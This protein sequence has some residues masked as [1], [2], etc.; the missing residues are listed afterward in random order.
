MAAPREK[1]MTTDKYQNAAQQRVLQTLLVLA[2]HGHEGI[3]PS[4]VARAVGTLPSNTTRDLANLRLAGLADE[5]HGR[6][7]PTERFIEAFVC[8]KPAR[9][10]HTRSRR[11]R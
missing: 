2:A 1:A 9:A 5:H 6:W 3:A 10:A 7:Y 11:S 4:E 8:A